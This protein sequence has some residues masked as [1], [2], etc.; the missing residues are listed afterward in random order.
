MIHWL[1]SLDVSLFRFVNLSM[2]N[3]FFDRLMP[4]VSGNP[5]FV[6][7]V[8]GIVA[9]LLWKGGLRARVYVIM[10]LLAIAFCDGA[11]CNSMKEAVGRFRPF[12][13]ILDTHIPPQVGRT[14]SWSMPSSHAA[15]WFTAATMTW[16]Y[17]R[18]SL[19]FMLPLAVLVGFSRIYNGVHYPSDVL[20]GTILGAGSTLALAWALKSLWQ[21]TGKRWFPA[22]HA[23]MPD[24]LNPVEESSS[25]RPAMDQAA[26]LRFGYIFIALLFVVR[27]AYLASGKIELSEDEAYQWLWSKHPAL[28]YYSKPPLIAYTQFLGTHIWGD[29]AFG[30]RFFSP[31]IAAV[32][33]L[34]I[35]RFIAREFSARSG[36]ALLL[37]C[38]TTILT[39]VGATLMTIDPLSVLFWTAA[40]IVG[41]RAS[42]PDGSTRHWLWVG[43]W[44][45]LGFLSKYTNLFQWLSWLL[46]FLLWPPARKHL[47]RPGPYLALLVNLLCAMPVLVWNAQHQWIT[48]HHVASDG[49]LSEP[50]HFSWKLLSY[51]GEFMGAEFGL[52]NPIFFVGMLW[53]AVGFWRDKNSHALAHSGEESSSNRYPLKL[54]LFCMGASVFGFYCM[55]SFHSRVY[56]NWIAPS[57]IPFF[58]LMVIYFGERWQEV[59]RWAKPLFIFGASLGLFFV[60]LA[61]DTN[62]VGKMIGRPIPAKLDVLR[63]VRGWSHMASLAGTARAKLA[64]EGKPA[65]II[66]DHYGNTSLISF[67][68][69]EAR[70]RAQTGA[71]PL[72]YYPLSPVPYNQFYFWTDYH[73][74]KG[75]NAIFVHELKDPPFSQGWLAK[76]WNHEAVLYDSAKLVG[77]A[78]PG[79]I[80]AQFESVT[81]LGISPILYRGRVLRHVQLFECRNLK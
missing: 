18:R 19:R 23:R 49:H 77:D 80:I 78:P 44:M 57:V 60:I 28:S 12:H 11:V 50:W 26:W 63:R 13:D 40:M 64:A 62:L 61:H 72:V 7:T 52:L 47:R 74:R 29:T 73:E 1:Q 2:Q 27:I 30:V 38:A 24:L 48:V 46:F 45:G 9:L 25:F 55:F 54:Y 51:F 20:A 69:P 37:I 4:F 70:Q 34:L 6:P 31:V 59:R 65:F 32:L 81:S 33:S 17:Y 53:A 5:L 36:V 35:L 58:C 71:E 56:P 8:V 41:W 68:L 66:G 75:Q 16:I 79:D 67:Y 3:A 43:L 22:W 76:W 21:W 42:Q 39:A 10:L 15:N 14:D